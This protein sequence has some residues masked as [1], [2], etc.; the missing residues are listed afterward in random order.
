M[1]KFLDIDCDRRLP[2]DNAEDDRAAA[3]EFFQFLRSGLPCAFAPASTMTRIV[4]RANCQVATIAV[5]FRLPSGGGAQPVIGVHDAARDHQS[6][7]HDRA[8]RQKLA[9]RA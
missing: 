1:L 3:V 2:A 8:M 5:A 4:G 7:P 9:K 6:Y